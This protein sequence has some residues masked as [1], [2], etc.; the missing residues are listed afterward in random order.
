MSN[1]RRITGGEDPT[2]VLREDDLTWL[3]RVAK[4]EEGLLILADEAGAPISAE[5]LRRC[6]SLGVIEPLAGE[7][8]IGFKRT[9]RALAF[10]KDLPP[11]TQREIKA[12]RALLDRPGSAIALGSKGGTAGLQRKVSRAAA[13]AMVVAALAF[14]GAVFTL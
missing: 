2:S 1:D 6:L 5:T 10:L 11:E 12:L 3:T 9:E 8:G 7:H 13:A 14:A 4:D